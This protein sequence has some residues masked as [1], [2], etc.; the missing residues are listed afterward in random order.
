MIY[1]E[2]FEFDS[3][4]YEYNHPIGYIFQII[5]ICESKIERIE[6][7]EDSPNLNPQARI[8]FKSKEDMDKF[9]SVYEGEWNED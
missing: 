1:S 6:I 7:L 2:E 3:I 8:Y 9:I 4:E 5:E